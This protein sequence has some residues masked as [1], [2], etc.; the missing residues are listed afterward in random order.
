[1][2]EIDVQQ[3]TKKFGEFT[4]VDGVSF[5]VEAGEIF[6]LLGPNGAGKST[7]TKILTTLSKPTSG[8]ASV[9]GRDILREHLREVAH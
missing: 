5:S 8:T 2:A 4:A 1:M 6:A 7:T 3:I 9:A